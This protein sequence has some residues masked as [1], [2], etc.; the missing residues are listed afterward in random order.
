MGW[1][2]RLL[3]ATPKKELEGICLDLDQPFWKLTGKT[4]FP[5]LL[6]AIANLLPEDSILYLEGGS[7]N[8]ELRAFFSRHAVP[9]REHVAVATLW[10]R[11]QCYHVPATRENLEELAGLAERCAA[12]ELAAHFHVYRQGKVLLEW[13][14]AF[15]Q[16][17]L[18]SAELPKDRVES[19][20]LA[21]SMSV[22]RW[23][24]AAG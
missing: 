12:P 6:R 21:L 10:P 24:N 22:K 19:F 18:L 16:P 11:P 7:P 15:T 23:K 3:G 5:C 1:L 13:H 4:D 17:M 20:A 2:R 8:K 9:E 14:D